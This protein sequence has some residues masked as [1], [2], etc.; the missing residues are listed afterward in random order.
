MTEP[1]ST[2][3]WDTAEFVRVVRAEVEA[4]NITREY[5]DELCGFTRGH[6]QKL[7]AVPPTRNP[8]PQTLFE[9]AGGAGLKVCLV[10]DPE[11]RAKMQRRRAYAQR[12][13]KGRTTATHGARAKTIGMIHEI[14]VVNGKLGAAARMAKLTPQQRSEIASI[15]AK[16]RWRQWRRLRR[17]AAELRSSC[18]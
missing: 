5:L 1:R 17:L 2:A 18:A 11:A 12:N 16:I 3:V 8:L 10:V 9:L 7:L 13:S 15:A 6:S 14:G 4:L